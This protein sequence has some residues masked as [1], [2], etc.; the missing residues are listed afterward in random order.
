MPPVML[1]IGGPRGGQHTRQLSGQPAVGIV[2]FWGGRAVPSQVSLVGAAFSACAVHQ[3][4]CTLGAALQ[5]PALSG[6]YVAAGPGEP[7]VVLDVS[8]CAV[9]GAPSQSPALSGLQVAAGPGAP[10]VVR[11]A[12]SLVS[13]GYEAS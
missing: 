1:Q 4:L 7:L 12:A 5:T 9:W 2:Q 8:A 6:L 3:S 10:L 13:A 11:F